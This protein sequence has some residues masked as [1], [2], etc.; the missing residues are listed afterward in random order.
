MLGPITPH[1]RAPRTD[2]G[3]VIFVYWGLC[4]SDA[5]NGPLSAFCFRMCFY[6]ARSPKMQHR[7]IFE[8][9]FFRQC[10]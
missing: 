5:K 2:S 10:R 1:V 8:G 7:P 6:M 9:V 4:P 3:P